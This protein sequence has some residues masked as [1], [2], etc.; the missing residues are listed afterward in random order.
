MTELQ[1]NQKIED[2]RFYQNRAAAGY[3]RQAAD[4]RPVWLQA[5]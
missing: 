5:A 2:G 3:R 1:Q 4:C